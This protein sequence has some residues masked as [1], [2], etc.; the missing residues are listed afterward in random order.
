MVEYYFIKQRK[1]ESG[2]NISQTRPWEVISNCHFGTPAVLHF[3]FGLRLY[4]PVNNFLVMLRRSHRSLCITSTFWEVNYVSCSRTQHSD[5]SEDRTP[6][7]RSVPSK[8]GVVNVYPQNE[9]SLLKIP[10]CILHGVFACV[11]IHQSFVPTSP[12]PPPT[13]I[14]RLRC[15][16]ITF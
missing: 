6:T 16:A 14:A 7:S 15:R 12:P 9:N 1:S 10:H 13:R 8:F 4:I 11:V 2:M 5:L 3:T